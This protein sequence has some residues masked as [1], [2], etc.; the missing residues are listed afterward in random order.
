[1]PDGVKRESP[2][3]PCTAGKAVSVPARVVFNAAVK[4]QI[5]HLPAGQIAECIPDQSYPILHLPAKQ[6]AECILDQSY[7]KISK[8][9]HLLVKLI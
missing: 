7:P 6:I 2:Q 9:L 3:T 5:L 1:M 8:G 4:N